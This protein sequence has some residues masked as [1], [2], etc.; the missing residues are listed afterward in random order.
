[1][2]REIIELGNP[3]LRT[4]AAPV[5]N[6]ALPE[7]LELIRDLQE[8]MLAAKGIGV[9]APQI[10]VS[11][12]VCII[13][14]RPNE[15]YPHAPFMEPTALINPVLEWQSPSIAKDWE[16]CLSI[17]GIRAL[18]PRP[19]EIRVRYLDPHSG[20]KRQVSYQGFVARVCMHEI[21]H[22][23][24]TV[25]LDRIE[26]AKDVVTEKEFRRILAERSK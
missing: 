4:E 2:L 6:Y 5:E 10:G 17:P 14:S 21:D 12:Q 18:V 1:M 26:S 13:A 11:L 3:V 16:G 19:T 20:E 15:R 7:V 23:Q 25:F 22:L 24:G 8:T 9:A